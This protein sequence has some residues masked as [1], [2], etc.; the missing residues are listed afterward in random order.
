VP[1]K[2]SATTDQR[3]YAREFREDLARWAQFERTGVAVP[4]VEV[5]VWLSELA[6]GRRARPPRARVL[7]IPKRKES[8]K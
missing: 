7:G 5:A 8:G 2:L 6:Q 3:R 4:H 1:G